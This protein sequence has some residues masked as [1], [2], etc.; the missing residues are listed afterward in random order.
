MTKPAEGLATLR[1]FRQTLYDD[2]LGL[3]QDSLF[4]LLDA[5]LTAPTATPLVRLSVCGAFRRRWPS[6]CDALADGSLEVAALRALVLAHRPPPAASGRPVWVGDGTV[7][8]RPAAATSPQRTYG[9]ASTDGTPQNALVAAWEYQ[10][11]VAVPEPE[12]GGSWALPLDVSRRG[13]TAAT[14]TQTAIAQ[15]RRARQQQRAQ[16]PARP[17]PVVAL[18]SGHDPS[19]LALADLDADVVVRL[20]KNRVFRRAPGPY[21]GRGAPA[22]HGPVFRLKDATTHG[23]PDRTATAEHPAYGTVTVDAWA[24]LHAEA[25]AAGVFTVVRVQVQHLPRHP[26]PQPLW[27]AWIGGPL[28]AD[29]R[30][31]WRWYLARFTVEHLFRFLKQALGWTTP[32]LRHPEAADR[33]TWLLALAVWQLW[34][35]RPLVA[36]Q[37]LPWER[38][39]PSAR[40]TPGRVRRAFA[41]LFA[42]LGSPAAAPQPRGNAPGRRLGQ[43]PRPAPRYAVEKRTHP[44]AA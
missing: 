13:P 25:C 21:G 22:K 4:D 12:A 35:A 8:P 7:W 6:T 41:G 14:P 16:D 28:P 33:W 37:R 3:R 34:L 19:Q 31:V 26:A 18:D 43:R 27:L 11:L 9:H 32:R 44:T 42:T 20:A 2:G 15:V 30:D 23:A 10:W 17:R 40:L 5:V 29:L 38:P 39:C 1:A 24:G 36:D